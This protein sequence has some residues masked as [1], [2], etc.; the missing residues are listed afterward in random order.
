M[1]NKHNKN[2][3]SDENAEDEL[4]Q[5]I[6]ECKALHHILELN[7]ESFLEAINEVTEDDNN[8]SKK[9]RDP[10]RQNRSSISS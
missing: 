7:I 8:S 2:T 1:Q 6:S 3:S 10:K 9:S 5:L 4:G